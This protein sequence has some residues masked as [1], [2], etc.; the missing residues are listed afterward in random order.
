MVGGFGLLTAVAAVAMSFQDD[1]IEMFT[2][3]NS[4]QK[5]DLDIW[6]GRGIENGLRMN[7]REAK[8]FFESIEITI[9]MEQRMSRMQTEGCNQ[10]IDRLANG[11][12]ALSQKPVISCCL[13]G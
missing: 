3:A 12:A 8:I 1:T 13:D 7:Y 6:A 11:I 5:A 10:A 9:A 2:P 4:T